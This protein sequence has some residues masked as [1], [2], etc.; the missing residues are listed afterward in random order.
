MTAPLEVLHLTGQTAAGE[1][2]T[3]DATVRVAAPPPPVQ[4]TLFGSDATP[5]N[6]TRTPGMRYTRLYGAPGRSIPS[7][8]NIPTGVLAH[9]SFKDDPTPALVNS[10][11]DRLPAIPKCQVFDLAG[12][13]FDT[14]LEWH[15]EFE[16][17]M[18]LD[19]YT[20]GVKA[21]LSAVRG[22]RFGDRVKV[23]QTFT[24]YAQRHGKTGPDGK[25]TSWRAAFVEGVP[26]I[27]M[28]FER[29]LPGYP[30][31]S[32]VY[33]PLIEA[34]QALA[35]MAVVPELGVVQ[36]ADDTAQYGVAAQYRELAREAVVQ[37]F[38]AVAA[39]D[40][41]QPPAT[42]GN[43]L[44]SGKVLAGWLDVQAGRI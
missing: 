36:A 20:G 11:L 25:T 29:D 33:A 26:V 13:P 5:I 34:K 14:I 12:D 37:R 40:T 27:G 30:A 1:L 4:P 22:H 24:G 2:V 10:W 31:A 42:T 17:D 6:M 7:V 19:S 35:V 28:D 18:P 32:I 3:V 8:Q 38:L 15:H 41:P 43:Y 23:C 21:L 44:M 39:Y 16:G 9:V